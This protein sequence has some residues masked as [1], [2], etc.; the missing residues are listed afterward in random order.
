MY[1]FTSSESARAIMSTPEQKAEMVRLHYVEHWRVGTIAS[2]MSVH[3]DL[4]KRVLGIGNQ[5][6]SG[7][8]R[9]KLVDPYREFIRQILEQYP[10][11]CSTREN[12]A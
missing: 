7:V 6:A 12:F 4:V 8:L 2:Q 10:K 5:N 9:A 11:L 1:G 3:P